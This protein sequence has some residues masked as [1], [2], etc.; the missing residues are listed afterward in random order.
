MDDPDEID[1]SDDDGDLDEEGEAEVEETSTL[2]VISSPVADPDAIDIGED[3]WDLV[4]YMWPKIIYKLFSEPPTV[5]KL[6]DNM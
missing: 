4:P 2:A 6:Y 5:H 1:L 3:Y